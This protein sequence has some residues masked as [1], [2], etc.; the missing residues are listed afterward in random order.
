MK[1]KGLINSSIKKCE[2]ENLAFGYVNSSLVFDIYDTSFEIEIAK[3]K[4]KASLLNK[5][6]HDPQNSFIRN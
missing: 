4:Y 2:D 1:N 5:A 3:K 6:L